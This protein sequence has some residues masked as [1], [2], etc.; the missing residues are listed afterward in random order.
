VSYGGCGERARE[1]GG[2]RERRERGR[3]SPGGRTKARRVTGAQ[4][5][6]PESKAAATA[7]QEEDGSGAGVAPALRLLVQTKQQ[8][9]AGLVDTSGR[10]GG[11][12]GRGG[13][14]TRRRQCVGARW[15]W[16]RG[17][18]QRERGERGGPGGVSGCGEPEGSR[19]R[20]PYPPRRRRRGG[21]GGDATWARTGSG[22]QRRRPGRKMG[23]AWSGGPRPIPFFCFLL[24]CFSFSIFL[25]FLYCFLLVTFYFSFVKCQMST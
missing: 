6:W 15:I 22:E 5:R 24:I 7:V 4:W 1:G 10:R 20:L 11:P 3:S 18:G 8:T 13:A 16:R 21:F 25:L 23:W 19:G 14:A 12:G 17:R 2:L 9:A